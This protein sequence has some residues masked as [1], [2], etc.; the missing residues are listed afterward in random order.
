MVGT[1]KKATGGPTKLANG[2]GEYF[3]KARFFLKLLK[4]TANQFSW[5]ANIFLLAKIS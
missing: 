4:K 3:K 1:K 5:L 2:V